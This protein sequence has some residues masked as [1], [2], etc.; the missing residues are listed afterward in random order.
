M[1]YS[2]QKFHRPRGRQATP[3][4]LEY[5]SIRSQMGLTS[6]RRDNI[7]SLGLCCISWLLLRH[8]PWLANDVRTRDNDWIILF[9]EIG[10]PMFLE[11]ID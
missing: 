5:G 6:S 7:M 2:G 3:Q 1:D 9:C 4:T 11:P 8:S 10:E